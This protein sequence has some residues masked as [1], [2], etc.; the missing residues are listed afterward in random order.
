MSRGTNRILAAPKKVLAELF[1][2]ITVHPSLDA[3][4]G[5]FVCFSVLFFILFV[6]VLFAYLIIIIQIAMTNELSS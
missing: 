4:P 6:F 2:I 5:T 1:R 3:F